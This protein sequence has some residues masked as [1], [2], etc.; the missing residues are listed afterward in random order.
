MVCRG[1]AECNQRGEAFKVT[2]PVRCMNYIRYSYQRHSRRLPFFRSTKPGERQS[3]DDPVIAY[4]SRVELD[5]PRHFLNTLTITS[6]TPSPAA[7]PPAILLHG[8]G[9][10]LGFFFRNF[11]PLA[12]WASQRGSAV[13]ALDW[14]GM[15]RS[16]RVPFTIKA[17]KDDIPGRVSEAESFFI[18]SLEQ[19]RVKVG[20]EKMTLV[21]HSL[22]AYFSV[23]YA[24]KYPSRVNK[25]VLLSPAGVPRDPNTTLPS[26]E[27]TDSSDT[28][29]LGPGTAE[30]A[31][32]PKLRRMKSHQEA[33]K[34][35]E[36]RTRRLFTYLWEEGWSPFQVVRASLFWGPWLIGKVSY[37]ILLTNLLFIPSCLP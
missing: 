13:Y 26:R 9:A 24:L 12:Q 4:T 1:E 35:E 28:Q 37:M 17:K 31:S 20:L 29:S 30:L 15:G 3:D 27:L 16:A 19:W 11:G 7:P 2:F 22:G 10:G 8:Y 6:T 25:L 33:E 5:T 32:E 34:K 18:D 23:A 21:G 36:S 14:L